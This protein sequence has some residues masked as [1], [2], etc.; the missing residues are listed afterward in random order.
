MLAELTYEEWPSE[1][2]LQLACEYM[3]PAVRKA[4]SVCTLVHMICT[5]HYVPNPC[6][7]ISSI[8]ICSQ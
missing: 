7:E 4:C 5:V 8:L 6:M 3:Q 1:Y 2:S